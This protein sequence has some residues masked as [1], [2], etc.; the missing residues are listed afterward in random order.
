[1]ST[2]AL[3]GVSPLKL[4]KRAHTDS[5]WSILFVTLSIGLAVLGGWAFQTGN[6]GRTLFGI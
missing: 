2:G 3:I 6:F 4:A 5:A 1:M